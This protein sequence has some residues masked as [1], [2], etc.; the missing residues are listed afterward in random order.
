MVAGMDQPNNEMWNFR[1]Y[2]LYLKEMKQIRPSSLRWLH[3]YVCELPTMQPSASSTRQLL[4]NCPAEDSNQTDCN[5][6]R[7]LG[8]AFLLAERAVRRLLNTTYTEIHDIFTAS[9]VETPSTRS[10]R[11]WID[12]IGQGLQVM[13]GVATMNDLTR[14]NDNI[15]QMRT[16]MTTS[17][18]FTANLSD[19]FASFAGLT[20]TKLT[21][22]FEALEN[23]GNFSQE[24][25]RS[26]ER[27]HKTV[28]MLEQYLILV[29]QNSAKF[30]LELHELDQ[31][32]WALHL[33]LLG[34]I[35]PELI[36]PK[37]LQLTIDSINGQLRESKMPLYLIPQSPQAIYA[38]ID[39]S[40]WRK[41]NQIFISLAFPVS[42]LPS[43]LTVYNAIVTPV[44]LPQNS[45][46]ITTL[47]NFPA[48]IAVHPDL[49]VYLTFDVKF[50]DDSKS[51]TLRLD[52]LNHVFRN[53]QDQSCESAFLNGDLTQIKNRCKFAFLPNGAKSEI[54]QLQPGHLLLINVSQ[55]TLACQNGTVRSFEPPNF[56]EII[57]PCECM[58]NAENGRF[59]PKLIDCANKPQPITQI[60]PINRIILQN[61][62]AE[63]KIQ[64]ISGQSAFA[65]APVLPI[66]KL[67]MHISNYTQ[68]IQTLR[69]DPQDLEA[70]VKAAKS[71]N[72]VFQSLAHKLT[73]DLQS[74]NFQITATS[75]RLNSWFTYLNAGSAILA[76]LALA[77]M[78][79][80]HR[81][82]QA[83]SIALALQNSASALP[84]QSD[85][86]YLFTRT[87]TASFSDIIPQTFCTVT[88][89][90]FTLDLIHSALMLA[91]LIML[92]ALYRA[93]SSWQHAKQ[94][95]DVYLDVIGQSGHSLVRFGKLPICKTLFK[96][97]PSEQDY[98]ISVEGIVRPKLII[99]PP[100]FQV[101]YGPNNAN[102]E[103]PF[104]V[105]ITWQQSVALR[106]LI[107]QNPTLV[108][109]IL[110]KDT[111]TPFLI[112]TPKVLESEESKTTKT[113][114]TSHPM[115]AP[116]AQ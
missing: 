56:V 107:N 49:D 110:E 12:L 46:H 18:K 74:D 112:K 115:G 25:V 66:P 79:R 13:F 29:L 78:V 32:K 64:Q 54:F 102:I 31:F 6:L 37:Q 86:S 61:W 53:K 47:Q 23:V 75:V 77:G 35:T 108:F 19:Q 101:N 11:A 8:K 65:E 81:K 38:G 40:I 2:G 39:F 105:T 67:S 7:Q 96:L 33:A 17:I 16:A 109:F 10:R 90:S 84:I 82:L 21:T 24:M 4:I 42:P 58:F 51:Q 55:F 93:F 59:Y 43:P 44:V 36:S 98:K 97:S 30:T 73:A 87:T 100:L 71:D 62:F 113:S 83:I 57:V 22:I 89:K 91:A 95:L 69:Q 52:Q 68:Q 5:K 85:L 3:T 20:Q 41:R 114:N 70:I 26:T 116:L 104:I 99:S 106:R 80:I 14:I 28:V 50:D 103:F 76:I 72:L 1:N 9:L 45:E 111:A 34:T 15:K 48:A 88:D 63:D 92:I 94:R 60:F 27:L